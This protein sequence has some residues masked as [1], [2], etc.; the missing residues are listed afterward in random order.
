MCHSPS[1]LIGVSGEQPIMYCR[2][3]LSQ[4]PA[5]HL[6]EAFFVANLVEELMVG[7][8]DQISRWES[9]LIDGP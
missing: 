7:H 4:R 6:C 2:S 9:Q 3:Q 5:N 1:V 8:H